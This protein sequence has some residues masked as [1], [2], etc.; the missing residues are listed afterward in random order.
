MFADYMRLPAYDL[1]RVQ[2]LLD[3]AY[4]NNS[5]CRG[6]IGQRRRKICPTMESSALAT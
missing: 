6:G 5:P 1:A 2:A 3:D 4:R